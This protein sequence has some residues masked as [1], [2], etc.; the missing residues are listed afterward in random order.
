MRDYG[1]VSPGFWT[2]KTGK[3]LKAKGPEA[4]IVALYLV[5][6]QHANMLGLYYLSKAYIAVDTPLGFE[7]ACKG[8]QG[9]CEAG[10]C[11]YDEDSEVVWVVEMAEY[12]IADRL[13]A[14]DN[15]C[16]GIQREYDALP[17]NPF[18]APFY[19]RYG[20]AFHM[21]A[22]RG[23]PPKK[24]RASKAPRKPLRSQEQEQEQEQEQDQEHEQEQEGGGG[25]SRSAPRT[26]SSGALAFDAYSAAYQARYSV[27]P[28]SNVK[29]RSQFAKLVERIG[30]DEAP[31]VAAWFVGHNNGYY[32]GR[33][34]SVDC[35]LSDAEKLRTEWATGKRVTATQAAQADRTQTNFD[36][37]APLLAE[38]HQQEQLNGK[39]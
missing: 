36:A 33:G 3:A 39:H 35:L 24:E 18:L 34:H 13:D 38:A 22:M 4:V 11:R 7:G 9:A 29:V 25:R 27:A 15:R 2:G 10:F 12:Q 21:T 20:E 28:V 32:V 1:K 16:K 37:F 31:Q 14:K 17:E 26:K 6:C 19:E 8:L 23:E 30:A 5:T